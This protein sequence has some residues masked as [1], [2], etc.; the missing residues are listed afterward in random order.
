MLNLFLFFVAMEFDDD[1]LL[2]QLKD[3]SIH[4]SKGWKK[5]TGPSQGSISNKG[6]MRSK[7]SNRETTPS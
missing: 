5:G 1:A 3:K 4:K 2:A 6:K 7:S